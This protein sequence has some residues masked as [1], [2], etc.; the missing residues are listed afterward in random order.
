[1]PGGEQ[2]FEQGLF[3]VSR[4]DDHHGHAVDGGVKII[5]ADVA[6]LQAVVLHQLIG[7]VLEV[8]VE[9]QDMVAVP[10]DRSGNVERQFVIETE[11]GADLI[12][13]VLGRMEVPSV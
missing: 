4:P 10:T 6:S 12:R 13:H 8:V 5:Q 7:D 11:H 3:H 9:L 2:G 1:M